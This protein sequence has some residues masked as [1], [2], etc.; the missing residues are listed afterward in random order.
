MNW[1]VSQTLRLLARFICESIRTPAEDGTGPF[2]Q[3]GGVALTTSRPVDLATE[4]PPYL[5]FCAGVQIAGLNCATANNFFI[6]FGE[7]STTQPRFGSSQM[8]AA[9]NAPSGYTIRINGTTLT[10]GN[11]VIPALGSPQLSSP[12]TSQFGANLRQ[13][14]N[15]GVGA[16]PVGP[17]VANPTADYNI[18]NRF[19]FIPNEVVV[20]S[21]TPSD[22]RKFTVS[23]IANV[24]EDQAPGVYSTTVTFISLANF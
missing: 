5:T 13:N 4:V 23:Y 15:P 16:N 1:A 6:N 8:L 24:N 12:G 7:F 11:N 19:K 21:L 18:P 2:V 3:A 14:T 9:T 20:R 22:T 10:S 17:G